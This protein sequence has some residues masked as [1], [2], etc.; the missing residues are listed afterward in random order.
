MMNPDSESLDQAYAEMA[1]DEEREAE[2][3]EWSEALLCDIDVDEPPDPL[4][5]A[6]P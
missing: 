4:Y 2:A 5:A 1:A 6:T 3:R